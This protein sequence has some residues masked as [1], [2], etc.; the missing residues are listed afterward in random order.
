M[1]GADRI[2]GMKDLRFQ[3]PTLSILSIRVKYSER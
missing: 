3:N 1:D 2:K